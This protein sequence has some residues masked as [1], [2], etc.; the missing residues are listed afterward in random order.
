M[1]MMMYELLLLFSIILICLACASY[2][3]LSALRP[4]Q[5]VCRFA[6]GWQQA[7]SQHNV[8]KCERSRIDGVADETEETENERHYSDNDMLFEACQRNSM[9]PYVCVCVCVDRLAGCLVCWG[10]VWQWVNMIWSRQNIIDIGHFRLAVLVALCS[11]EYRAAEYSADIIFN[12]WL[13]FDGQL[14]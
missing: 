3:F 13:L 11:R 2:F 12:A 4:L 9:L 14:L 1:M 10:V 6:F 5:R 8:Y 7:T